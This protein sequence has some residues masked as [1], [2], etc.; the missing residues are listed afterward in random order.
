[1][2]FGCIADDLTG[3]VEIASML[4]AQGVRTGLTIG[5][6]A[7]PAPGSDGHVVA[8][9]SRVAPR[10]DAVSDVLAAASLLRASGS[11]QIFFKYCA[12][13]DST[14]EG[15]IG[16]C[17]EALLGLLD[18][19]FTIFAPSYCEVGRTVFQ[20][21]MFAGETLLSESPKRF[22]PL[23]PM[24]D[25]NL[26]RVL[27][28]QSQR[29]VG[30]VPH[31]FV[32]A[33]PEAVRA[34]M[35]ALR[36][37]GI[38]LAIADAVYEKDLAVLAR[39]CVDLPLFTGNSSV[40]AHLPRVWRDQGLLPDHNVEALPGIPG[41]A[42]VLVGSCAERTEAQLALFERSHPVLRLDLDGAFAGEDLVGQA[43]AWAKQRIGS[44]PVAI[45]TAA[46]PDSV[47]R[48]QAAHGRHAVA[49]RAEDI[50]S[51]LAAALVAEAG[52][53]RLVVA[54]G[55]TS[56]AVL[57]ALGIDRLEV[58]PYEGPGLARVVARAPVRMALLL[59][60]GK[61]GALDIFETVLHAMQHPIAPADRP[62]T[63]LD[64]RGPLS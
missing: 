22:D 42:A 34:R 15:N 14:P 5:T 48:L 37:E 6:G 28:A 31:A 30:L 26:V 46:D 23:T 11:R 25:S 62:A 54:G 47:A 21:H 20:G 40:A 4:V 7:R 63:W 32:Q 18:A 1:M 39:S 43:M 53:R 52:I 44:G 3:G 64:G 57:K 29:R 17:A 60:S 2:L 49:A 45:S 41:N 33:G 19:D 36:A 16:P 13:F 50:L 24:T 59:K 38:E 58:G 9:K 55:E 12:T 8:L 61:L 27:A 35:A 51:A 10:D 56:G